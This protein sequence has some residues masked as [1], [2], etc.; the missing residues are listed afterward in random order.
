MYQKG[1]SSTWNSRDQPCKWKHKEDKAV[2]IEIVGWK[3]RWL[4]RGYRV[5]ETSLDLKAR[6]RNYLIVKRRRVA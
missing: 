4:A 2:R 3:Y 1:A 6:G 5:V